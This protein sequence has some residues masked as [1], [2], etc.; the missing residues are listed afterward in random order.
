MGRKVWVRPEQRIEPVLAE[1][2][3]RVIQPREVRIE[4][5][6]RVKTERDYHVDARLNI[7]N[8]KE[9]QRR[10]GLDIFSP[11]QLAALDDIIATAQEKALSELNIELVDEDTLPSEEQPPPE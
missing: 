3:F 6:Q 5:G 11:E 10:S 9:R 4:G 2:S 8:R 1:I 7:D